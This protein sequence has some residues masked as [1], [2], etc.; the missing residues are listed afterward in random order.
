MDTETQR[1]GRVPHGDM[2]ERDTVPKAT[3][4][5]YGPTGTSI[6][7]IKV[8]RVKWSANEIYMTGVEREDY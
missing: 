4:K 7:L 8:N 3:A 6:V 2:T 1:V 5:S